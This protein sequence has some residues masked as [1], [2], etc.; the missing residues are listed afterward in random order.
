MEA[1]SSAMAEEAVSLHLPELDA[2]EPLLVLHR[3][4]RER[5]HRPRVAELHLVLGHVGQP[6]VESRA[7]EDQRLHPL[8]SVP[9]Q[10]ALPTPP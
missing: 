4:P 5:V 2:T 3:L 7:D 9:I 1:G 10:D 6:L 8:T